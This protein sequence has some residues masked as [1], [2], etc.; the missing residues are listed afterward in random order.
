MPTPVAYLLVA[1]FIA[2]GM[3]DIGIPLLA[4]HMFLFYIAVKSASTPPVG[5]AAMIA[6]TMAKTDWWG[7]AVK[8]VVMSIPAFVLAFA[9]VYHPELL[10]LE[11]DYYSIA[12]RI[13]LTMIGLLGFVFAIQGYTLF[14]R[15]HIVERLFLL[16]AGVFVITN[17]TI[18]IVIGIL[19][20][21]LLSLRTPIYDYFNNKRVNAAADIK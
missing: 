12:L 4:A 16:A 13:S 10:L 17:I 20:M 18:L 14:A 3:V 8:S 11:G 19:A 15:L 6:S 2:P 9:F 7:T 1:L 5:T 21:V